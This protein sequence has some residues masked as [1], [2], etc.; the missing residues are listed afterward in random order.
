MGNE[1]ASR[2]NVTVKLIHGHGSNTATELTRMGTTLTEEKSR[3]SVDC[4]FKFRASSELGKGNGNI[5]P[6]GPTYKL[7]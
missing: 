4:F 5:E 1:M 6:L 7:P 2:A 3:A